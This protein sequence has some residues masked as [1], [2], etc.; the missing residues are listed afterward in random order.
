[1]YLKEKLRTINPE[2]K[3]KADHSHSN[4]Q[5]N[6][7]GPTQSVEKGVSLPSGRST[8]YSRQNSKCWLGKPTLEALLPLA[9]RGFCFAVGALPLTPC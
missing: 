1:M 3:L 4:W 8:S 7:G 9:A 6:P 5:T 2:L